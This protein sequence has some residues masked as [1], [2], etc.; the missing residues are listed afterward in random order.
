M[1]TNALSDTVNWQTV[2]QLYKI[3]HPRLDDH[4]FTKEE[5][6][7]VAELPEIGS[8]IVLKC[9]YLGTNWTT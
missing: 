4:Q 9:L 5:L 6:E 2:E 8:Q 3:S 1:L 7:S